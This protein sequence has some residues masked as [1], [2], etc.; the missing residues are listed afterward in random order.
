MVMDML[1]KCYVDECY[2]YTMIIF[3]HANQ[4]KKKIMYL[5]GTGFFFLYVGLFLPY[6]DIGAF[7]PRFI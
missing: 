5:V 7:F 3:N 4:N 2:D 1:K 6:F